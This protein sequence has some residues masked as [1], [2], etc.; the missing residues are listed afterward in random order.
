MFKFSWSKYSS[1][2]GLDI[3]D[4]SIEAV[5]LKPRG[6]NFELQ[7]Y[8]R[9][10][11]PSGIVKKGQF[12]EKG[13]LMDILNQLF[14]QA[15]H[16]RFDKSVPLVVNLPEEKVLSHVFTY[17]PPKSQDIGSVVTQDATAVVPVDLKAMV[18]DWQE[19]H[20][21]MLHQ[22]VFWA[23]VPSEYVQ[24]RTEI[25]KRLG[26]NLAA[27]DMESAALFRALVKELPT[28]EA[29]LILDIGGETTIMAIYDE[30]GIRSSYNAPSG[31]HVFTQEIADQL[32]LPIKT[33]ELQKREI[34]FKI[35]RKGAKISSVL[36]A[37]MQVV[38]EEA[39]K[40]IRFY[41]K[42]GQRKVKRIILT[43][44]SSLIPGIDRYLSQ[45]LQL[46]VV[47]GQVW[48]KIEPGL[49]SN[50]AS[51]LPEAV[52]LAL[53]EVTDTKAINFLLNK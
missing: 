6:E 28:E 17:S 19:V 52:G 53:R 46:E 39:V 34:G 38:V 21:D 23:G 30:Y 40:G 50:M 16:G 48:I 31:G 15:H 4:S 2:I 20:K 45:L 44:G 3:S 27:I 36:Q 11:L 41:E 7:G 5:Q 10:V 37:A 43:G 13:K 42:S 12:V 29:V 18:W 51:L 9:L 14:V 26:F 35:D 8:S 22:E 24:D 1:A 47:I 32:K 33:A 49:P 25:L